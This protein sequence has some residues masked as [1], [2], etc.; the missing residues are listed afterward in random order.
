VVRA[1]TV[2]HGRVGL[3]GLNP[4]RRYRVTPMMVDYLP[5]GLRTPSWWG[6]HRSIADEYAELTEGDEPHWI[7]DRQSL[8]VELRGSVLTDV[9]LMLA[10]FNPDHAVLYHVQ[11]TKS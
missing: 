11:A 1:D 3:P 7:S 2:F 10:P 8:G 9:G 4:D 6:F 5:S